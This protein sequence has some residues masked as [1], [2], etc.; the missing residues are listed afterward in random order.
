MD[1]VKE[2]AGEVPLRPKR[3]VLDRFAVY[4]RMV[5]GWGK[6][7]RYWL[8]K[9]RRWHVEHMKRTRRGECRRCGACCRFLFKCPYL[10]NGSHCT[11]YPRRFE[12]CSNFPIDHRDLRYFEENC[13]FYF[14]R[15]KDAGTG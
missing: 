14:V 13:G 15:R 6:A 10:E 4:V 3:S 2:R 1:V 8:S 12:Q 11:I 7:R 5:E 9:F